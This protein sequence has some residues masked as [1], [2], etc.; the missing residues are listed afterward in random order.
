SIYSRGET[1]T[2]RFRTP[3]TYPPPADQNAAPGG[4]PQQA[5]KPAAAPGGTPKTAIHFTT[6]LP[7]F[8]GPGLEDFLISKGVEI[9]AEPIRKGDS[10]WA[11]LLF[12]FGPALLLIGFYFWMYRRAAL[13]GG[14]LMG[15][16]KSMA[17]RYDQEADTKVTFDDVAGI[18]EAEN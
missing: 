2:G 1:L 6:V 5:S 8:V 11:T 3:V 18:D 13:Q 9:S 14:G 15:I 7:S 17:R 12:G 16:G 10:P 4:E